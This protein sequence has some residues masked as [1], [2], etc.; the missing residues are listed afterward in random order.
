M[1]GMRDKKQGFTL[2]E[3]LIVT[4]VV[5]SLM[6]IVF[7]LTGIAGNA[8]NRETTVHRLQ[9]LENCL[10]GYYATFGS[11]PPVP[12]QGATRNIYRKT[13]DDH[14]SIQSDD[15]QDVDESL[16]K[17][18]EYNYVDA[19]CRAQ[20]VAA[21]YPPPSR[22]TAVVDGKSREVSSATAYESFQQAVLAA[23]AADA[24]SDE[25][26]ASIDRW[27]DS[28]IRD[29]GNSPGFLNSY[30]NETDSTRLQLF[31]YGLMSFLL[32]RYRF[33][34]DCAKGSQS[35]TSQ[36][37]NTSI[38]RYK[39]WTEFNP[40]PSR[41][42]TGIAYESWKAFCDTMGGEDDWQIDL[43]PSQAACARWM[44]NL[45]D[46]V[47]GPDKTFFGVNVG[48]SGDNGIPNVR[49]AASF[50]LYSPGGRNSS[51]SSGYPLL[52]LTVRDGWGRDFYYYSPAPYQS[53]VLWSAGANGRTFP[54]WIDL[55]QFRQSHRDQYEYAVKWMAD[56]VKFMSTGK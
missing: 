24:Y 25:E 27:K 26:K 22:L 46:M 35:G 42:D 54:P 47:S 50:S 8:S 1:V 5:V 41:M 52:S 14:P 17:F 6:A 48:F 38:D 45:K 16:Q 29:I 12:L 2:I 37:F 40:L 32:P 51:S 34:L 3:L 23:Y 55:E 9:C 33:M 19:A 31:R 10:S 56:D 53:Y 13:G 49:N 43:I 44:P 18:K 21:M 15:P 39:Q 30:Q 20:P 28:T 36:S 4:V 11:Y 7:R